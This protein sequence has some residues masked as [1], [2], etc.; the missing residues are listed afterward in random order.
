MGKRSPGAASTPESARKHKDPFANLIRKWETLHPYNFVD[1]LDLSAPIDL[2]NVV[3]AAEE[4]LREMLE[5]GATVPSRRG[6]DA[7]EELAWAFSDQEAP[8]RIAWE[9]PARLA[10]TFRHAYFDGAGAATF[11]KRTVRRALGLPLENLVIAEPRERIALRSL[12]R[13][14]RD[15]LRMRRV[16]SRGARPGDSLRNRVR[17]LDLDASL[18]ER[19]QGEAA[20]QQATINDILA[21]RLASAMRLVATPGGGRRRETSIAIA[22]GMRR[23]DEPFT[24]GIDVAWFPIFATEQATLQT[25]RD[26]TAHEKLTGAWIRSRLEM[27]VASFL[28]SWVAPS[29]RD[30]YLARQYVLTAGLTNLRVNTVQGIATHRRVVATGPVAPLVLS[31]LTHGE[32]LSLAISWRESRFSDA[33]IDAIAGALV[34]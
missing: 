15:L 23:E 10:F 33:E 16:H 26:Q 31:A 29:A 9:P 1:V 12:L 24:R 13:S 2:T 17:F 20:T 6:I 4:T 18:L 28:W 21:T 3:E 27:R 34:A 11:V 7:E 19:L 30:R 22:V 8:V 25:I 5:I 32:R 14:V